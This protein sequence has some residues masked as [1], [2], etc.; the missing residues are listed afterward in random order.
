M[1]ERDFAFTGLSGGRALLRDTGWNLAGS[2]VPLLAG[3][4]AVPILIDALGIDRFGVLLLALAI[5]GYFAIF[6]PGVGRAT[7]KYVAEY[8][9]TDRGEAL[10]ALAW[11]SISMLG[12]LGVLAGVVLAAVTP[13]TADVLNLPADLEHETEI[14]FFVLATGLPAVVMTPGSEACWKPNSGLQP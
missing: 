13:L 5:L 10:R 8:L 12:L 14:A 11:T 9:A 2:L 6:D 1:T 7:T 4:V 3:I